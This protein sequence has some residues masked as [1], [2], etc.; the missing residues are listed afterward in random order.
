MGKPKTSCQPPP[1]PPPSSSMELVN[2]VEIS[3]LM[4]LEMPILASFHSAYGP[5]L[6]SPHTHIKYALFFLT[7]FVDYILAEIDEPDK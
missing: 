4:F 6:S 3:K 7:V 5:Y 1:S 2:L